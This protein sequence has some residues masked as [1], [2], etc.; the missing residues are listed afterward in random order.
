MQRY[1]GNVR[2]PRNIIWPL[3]VPRI[4]WYN[5]HYTTDSV[6]FEFVTS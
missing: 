6:Y 1:K 5:G 4:L 3:W 2:F